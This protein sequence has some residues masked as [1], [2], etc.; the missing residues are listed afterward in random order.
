MK[1]QRNWYLSLTALVLFGAAPAPAEP[2]QEAANKKLVLDFYNELYKG[3]ADGN[4][5]DR[6][7]GIAEKYM[8]PDY[9]QHNPAFA[10]SGGGRE[11]F[12]RVMQQQPARPRNPNFKPPE[13]VAVMAEGDRV[14]LFTKREV[15]GGRDGQP[16]SVYIFNMFRI[17][18]SKFAEHWDAGAGPPGG[19]TRESR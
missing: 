12:I 9:I 6:I 11:A 8:L 16:A 15:P 18:D 13:T 19:G 2:P 14:M 4:L 10:G 7:A 3:E 5:K 1:M 17:K